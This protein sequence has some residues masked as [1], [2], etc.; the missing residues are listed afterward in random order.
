M[1]MNTVNIS[2]DNA[3]CPICH[4]AGFV[5]REVPLDHPDFGRAIPCECKLRETQQASLDELRQTSGITHLAQMTFATFMPD[6]IGL[7]PDKR[8]NLREAYERARQFA[9]EPR[10]WL[11]LKG[12]YG[13]GKTH[14]AAAIAN[15]RLARNE[16]A[17]FVVVP[18]LLDHLRATFAPTSRVSYDERF[19]GIRDAAF[20]ILDDFG[21]QSATAWAQ[22]KLFQLLNHRYNAQLPTVIT[23]NRELEE[24]E[25]R[26]RSRFGDATLCSIATILAPDFRQGGTDSA[27]STLSNLSFY[28]DMTFDSFDLRGDELKGDER[29]SLRRVVHIAQDYAAHPQGFI[30]FTGDYGCGKTHLAAAIANSIQHSGHSVT[31]VVVADL[32]DHLRA[33]FAPGSAVSLDQRFEETRTAPFLVLDDFGAQS[34]TAW[35]SE[36]LFQIVDYRYI[37]RLPTV[38]TIH[39]EAEIDPRIQTR[40]FDLARSSVNEILAPS[41][42][43]T[44]RRAQARP[45][46]PAPKSSRTGY[47][48]TRSE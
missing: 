5:R 22:E 21:A 34:A 48:R 23:T 38:I 3:V 25:P 8:K 7:N 9:Q 36:K 1:A 29:A 46:T 40:I 4:G 17:L 12:G 37:A 47:S 28:A 39:H 16:P 31:F 18:D 14:L 44:H 10:G 19:E 45:A 6:G 15:D 13:S 26:L 11:L 41:Y 24:I 30:V 43:M 35:A 32:L 33:T 42:R 2:T 27:R 20:L